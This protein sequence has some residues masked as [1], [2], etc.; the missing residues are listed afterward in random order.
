MKFAIVLV[1]LLGLMELSSARRG[2]PTHQSRARR[3]KHLGEWL[4]L[5]NQKVNTNKDQSNLK[6]NS[7]RSFNLAPIGS[8]LNPDV[9]LAAH[10]NLNKPIVKY[11]PKSLTDYLHKRQHEPRQAVRDGSINSYQS[12]DELP[13]GP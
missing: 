1:I 4:S 8:R 3:V 12:G 6:Y 13:A 10:P 9:K 11:E 5:R 7:G 2:P